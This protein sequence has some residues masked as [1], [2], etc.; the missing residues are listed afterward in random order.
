MDML[1]ER[2]EQLRAQEELDS[3]RPDI[4]GR[5]VMERLGV[6]PGPVIGKALAHLLELRIDEGPLGEDEALRRLDKWWSEQGS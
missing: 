6:A 5:Q 2:I 4:D 1:E 3:L